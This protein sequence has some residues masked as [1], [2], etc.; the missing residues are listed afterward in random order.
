MGYFSS[1]S[2]PDHILKLISN[3]IISHSIILLRVDYDPPGIDNPSQVGSGTFVS[4][5]EVY[6]ILTAYHVITEF[7]S[8]SYL[9]LTLS[10][11]EDDYKIPWKEL[12]L[13]NIGVPKTSESGPDLVFIQLS[14]SHVKRIEKYK[15]F[16]SL[17]DHKKELLTNPL[18]LDIGPWVICG[19]LQ[20]RSKTEDSQ[21]RF[22]ACLTFEQFCGFGSVEREYSL[23]GF[24]YLEFD[25]EHPLLKETPRTFKGMSGGGL[26][27]IPMNKGITDTFIPSRFLLSGVIFWRSP[28]SNNL[29]Y[30]KCHGRRSIYEIVCNRVKE[31]K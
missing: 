16:Y 31:M 15:T 13:L 23:Y 10:C 12:I 24:D 27:Q 29:R 21:G 17:L 25:L 3:T 30:L 11:D 2:I 4:N 20:E 5:G 19:G 6:G 1:S 28:V 8:T 18:D 9:G 7:I 26:W 14:S 22:S